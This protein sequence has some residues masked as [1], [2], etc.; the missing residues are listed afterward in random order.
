VKLYGLRNRWPQ[1]NIPRCFE[2]D[3]PTTSLGTIAIL[4]ASFFARADEEPIPAG[5]SGRELWPELLA[6]AL[7][8]EE[9]PSAAWKKKKKVVVRGSRGE[10]EM[11][12]IGLYLDSQDEEMLVTWLFQEKCSLIPEIEYDTNTYS[13]CH[14]LSEFGRFRRLTRS[15]FVVRQ[16]YTFT[17]L[18]LT[19]ASDQGTGKERKFIMPRNGGP[20]LGLLLCGEFQN[21]NG[22]YVRPGQ[23]SY[24]RSYWDPRCSGN[25]PVPKSLVAFFGEIGEWISNN[26]FTSVKRKREYWVGPGAAARVRAGARLVG[27]ESLVVI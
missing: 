26:N 4:L 21:N 25:R 23:V 27:L 20:A 14:N 16:D 18:E 15:Y 22:Q 19:S 10:Y 17:E 5:S 24:Y 1:C 7:I 13:V 9:P 11:P 3:H 12:E 8:L 2:A 6:S